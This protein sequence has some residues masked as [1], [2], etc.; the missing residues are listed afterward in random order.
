MK[1]K[2]NFIIRNDLS[3]LKL[4]NKAIRKYLEQLDLSTK[5]V[6][7]ITLISEELISNTI[8]HGYTDDI[9][10]EISVDIKTSKNYMK[11]TIKDDGKKFNVL[12]HPTPELDI[13]LKDMKVGGLGIYL[14]KNLAKKFSYKRKNHINILALKL[15]I[16]FK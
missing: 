15:K 10:H 7:N 9:K 12:E 14:V 3:E 11:I 8:R 16:T 6:Y 4:L 2:R 13:P 5:S 1:E